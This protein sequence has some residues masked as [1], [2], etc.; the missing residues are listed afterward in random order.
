[1][2]CYICTYCTS[3]TMVTFD[4][5]TS[6]LLIFFLVSLERDEGVWDNCRSFLGISVF[7]LLPA[8][9][10]PP[11]SLLWSNLEVLW[12][13]ALIS[14]SIFLLLWWLGSL[15]FNSAELQLVRFLVFT[16]V[17]VEETETAPVLLLPLG[18]LIELLS[19]G[20]DVLIGIWILVDREADDGDLAL[21]G[22]RLLAHLGV[23][24]FV[25][26]ILVTGCI[27]TNA[28]GPVVLI[29]GELICKKSTLF[30][31]YLMHM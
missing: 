21:T 14:W 3:L 26:N 10:L 19:F 20:E 29:V 28:A 1:M 27:F 13:L 5:V 9:V 15:L 24:T 2:F 16:D 18:V 12:G 22:M 11:F 7:L 17:L 23:G 30:Q 8:T 25:G 4:L 31:H 6:C